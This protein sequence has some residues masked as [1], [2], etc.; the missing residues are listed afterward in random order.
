[1]TSY[2]Q[3]G[4]TLLEM[5]VSVA[6]F[7]LV[8]L[9]AMSAY[10]TLI[11]IDKKARATNALV[12]NLSF[13]V[14]TMARSIRTGTSYDCGVNGGDCPTG[15]TQFS[16]NDSDGCRVTYKLSVD[17]TIRQTIR[18]TAQ[19]PACNE[20]S[21]ALLTDSSINIDA[22]KFYVIGTDTGDTIQP[23]VTFTIHG[24]MKADAKGGTV[25]YAIQTSATQ[26]IIDL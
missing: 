17:G 23:Y 6:I 7:S 26:R 14:D 9:A 4:Y 25:D 13:A 11:D 19:A 8:M 1:M 20:V 10:L 2:P 21:N 5:L 15:D 16:F 3:R 18:S 12:N 22:M 24:S